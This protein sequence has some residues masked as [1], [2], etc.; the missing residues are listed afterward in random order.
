MR[1]LIDLVPVLAITFLLLLASI[2]DIQSREVSDF[3]WIILG[4]IGIIRT[5]YFSSLAPWSISLELISISL[6]VV[7]ALAMFYLGLMGGADSKALI[8]L[9]LAFPLQP[10]TV[11]IPNSIIPLF[12]L[13]VLVNA[14]LL[15]LIVVPYILM[16][17]LS[18]ILQ[19]RNLFEENTKL[20]FWKKI[21][22][23]ITGVKEKASK[24]AGNV[25]YR[26]LEYLNNVGGAPQRS[27]VLFQPAEED[28]D[29]TETLRTIDNL[30]LPSEIWV[31][32]TLPFLVFIT[33]G[34]L[35]SIFL[36]DILYTFLTIIW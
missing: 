24:I 3:I 20:A 17:N 33:S 35:V 14:I 5:L 30:D 25:N 19:G 9:S 15:S 6:I 2:Q 18:W 16:R 28:S 8:A 27:Y 23:L 11:F 22:F 32:P 34:F 21:L 4:C 10:D 7:L 29:L 13:S 12:P 36:G 26:P 1:F 31:T